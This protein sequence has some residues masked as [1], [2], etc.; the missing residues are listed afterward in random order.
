MTKV[1]VI[2]RL[3]SEA[4]VGIE[5]KPSWVMVLLLVDTYFDGV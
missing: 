4:A 3:F 1:A 2:Q 5:V